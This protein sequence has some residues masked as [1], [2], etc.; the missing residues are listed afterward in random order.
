MEE[1][2]D[3]APTCAEC[4]KEVA[5][6]HRYCLHCG[7]YLG[8]QAETINVF[9]NENLRRVFIFFFLYL[10]ICL[11]VK[12][13]SWFTSY[14]E[15]FWIEIALAAITLRFAWLNREALKPVLRFNN[16]KWYLV[17]GVVAISLVASVIVNFSVREVNVTFFNSDVSYLQEYRLYF[18]PSLVMVYSIAIMPAIFEEVA[19]RGIMYNYC[20][21]FLDDKLVV[22]VTAFL[23][24]IMHLNLISLVWL[25]PFGFFI[26]HLRYRYNTIWYGVIFHFIFNLTAVGIDLYRQGELF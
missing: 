18:F 24:A 5:T 9:N 14:D 3:I 16:Y 11:L 10:F 25:I 17:T 20:S 26:G 22:A 8:T 19:F 13:T 1:I 7:A 6:H 4:E 12:Y 23:F 2:N 15:I 21:T